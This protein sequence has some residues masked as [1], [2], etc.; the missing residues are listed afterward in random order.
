MFPLDICG[1]FQN[2]QLFEAD[3]FVEIKI[4]EAMPACSLDEVLCHSVNPG[5]DYAVDVDLESRGLQGLDKLRCHVVNA[6]GD[7]IV[8]GRLEPESANVP[9]ILRRYI[10]NAYRDEIVSIR[11]QAL[12]VK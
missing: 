8:D 10:V 6:H 4:L 5:A 9:N 2:S 7:Q 3:E 11:L 12:L 1:R